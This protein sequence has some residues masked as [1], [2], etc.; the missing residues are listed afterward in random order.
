MKRFILHSLFF[1]SIFLATCLGVFSFADGSTDAFYEKFTTPKQQ[2][3]VIGSSRAA[4]G[5]IPK[6]MNDSL[7]VSPLYNYAFTIAHT[8]FGRPYY[9][10]IKRKLDPRSKSGLFLVCVNPWTVSSLRKYENDSLHYREEG[11]FIENTHFVSFK[12]NIEYLMESF[13]SKN[14]DILTNKYRK[15]EYQTFFV[16]DDGWLRVTIESDMIS[17]QKRTESKLKVYTKKLTQYSGLSDYR[18][19]YL[20][21]TIALLQQHGSVYLVRLP[22]NDEMLSI[23]Q[24]L[25]PDFDSKMD[26]LSTHFSIPYFNSIPFRHLYS[27]TDSNHLDIPSAEAFSTMLGEFIMKTKTKAF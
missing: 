14:I 13:Q 4:Q 26:Q 12:P 17:I 6:V 1:L 20:K 24:Q 3:L 27:Y 23:E 9:N 10:S 8:A 22:V 25:V 11:S 5:I 7:G 16:E 21:K 15:G 2:S 19:T 18:M